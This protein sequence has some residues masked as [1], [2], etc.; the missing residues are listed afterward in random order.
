MEGYLGK[1]SSWQFGFL[2]FFWWIWG[3]IRRTLGQFPGKLTYFNWLKEVKIK[4][5]LL[6]FLFLPN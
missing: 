2:G 6:G 5:L 4:G 1:T 3:I